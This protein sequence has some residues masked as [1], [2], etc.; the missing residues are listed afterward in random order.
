MNIFR[1]KRPNATKIHQFWEVLSTFFSPNKKYHNKTPFLIKK[2]VPGGPKKGT[3]IKYEYFQQFLWWDTSEA[4]SRKPSH[5]SIITKKITIV[6]IILWPLSLVKS[7][8]HIL[9]LAK[10]A[11]SS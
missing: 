7:D 6:I 9:K 4:C 1:Q 2:I 11:F 5:I 10:R 3:Q 8:N